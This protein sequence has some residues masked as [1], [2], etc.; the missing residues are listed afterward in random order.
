[1]IAANCQKLMGISFN[2]SSSNKLLLQFYSWETEAQT[3]CVIS[4]NLLR[5]TP[6]CA[7]KK[8][9][10]SQQMN[11][12]VVQSFIHQTSKI[13]QQQL[14]Q[15]TVLILMLSHNILPFSKPTIISLSYLIPCKYFNF[16]VETLTQFWPRSEFLL[17]PVPHQ[18][19][20][21]ELCI[22][23]FSPAMPV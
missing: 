4:P 15:E 18:L 19:R 22:L 8:T 16:K 7:D 14:N 17:C 2:I 9:L 1:M 10:S 21:G 5:E 6:G 3:C 23:G 20:K 13:N 12:F 11:G